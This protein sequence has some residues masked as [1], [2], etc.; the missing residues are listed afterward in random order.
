MF[1]CALFFFFFFFFEIRRA[2]GVAGRNVWWLAVGEVVPIRPFSLLIVCFWSGALHSY[3]VFVVGGVAW[4]L[5]V[6]CLFRSPLL[7]AASWHVLLCVRGFRSC[8]GGVALSHPP[9]TPQHSGGE[10][11][12]SRMEDSE[13]AHPHS[14]FFLLRQLGPASLSPSRRGSRPLFAPSVPS[15]QRPPCLLS[16]PHNPNLGRCICSLHNAINTCCLSVAVPR[17]T[18]NKCPG[19]CRRYGACN[20]NGNGIATVAV[21]AT[22][23]VSHGSLHH[24]GRQPT[25]T[26]YAVWLHVSFP[27][28]Y[29]SIT[30]ILQ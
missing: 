22:T 18:D 5:R 7:V 21:G 27:T 1:V 16:F 3:D 9:P 2:T 23:T 8:V 20:G 13:S 26:R 24:R 14:R 19:R 10:E 25:Y 28:N 30:T 15:I 11:Y 12:S 17:G 6:R 29:T 4:T